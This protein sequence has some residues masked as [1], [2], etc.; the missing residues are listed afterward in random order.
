MDDI[1]AIDE[2]DLEIETV[3]SVSALTG[4]S[5]FTPNP[6]IQK[7]R[8]FTSEMYNYVKEITVPVKQLSGLKFVKC[9]CGKEIH[10]RSKDGTSAV[11][12]T[13]NLLIDV[14]RRPY[15]TPQKMC[16]PIRTHIHNF[17]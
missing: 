10:Y 4:D 16:V 15:M 13:I 5:L 1:N 7:K 2:A 17:S 3:P 8:K 14:R 9:K 12:S 6:F 11:C